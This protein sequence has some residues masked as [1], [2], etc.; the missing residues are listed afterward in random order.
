M[1]VRMNSLGKGGQVPFPGLCHGRKLHVNRIFDV[2]NQNSINRSQTQGRGPLRRLQPSAMGLGFTS[3]QEPLL[4]NS[5]HPTLVV[6]EYGLSIPQMRVLGLTADGMTK[7]PEV[8]AVRSL[9]SHSGYRL[10]V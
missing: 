1:L 5:E 9:F 8:E 6:P 3:D 7:V 4:E 2:F 10:A